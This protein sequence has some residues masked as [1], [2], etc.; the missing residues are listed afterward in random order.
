RT[1]G[2]V[3]GTTAPAR[4]SF[5]PARLFEGIV[6]M[7][8][9]RPSFLSRVRDL[10]R[11]SAAVSA[12][13]RLVHQPTGTHLTAVSARYEAAQPYGKDRSWL[14]EY[15]Q[16]ARQ[17]I[18]AAERIEMLRKSRYFEKNNATYQKILDLIEVNVVGTGVH[19]TPASDSP[20]WNKRA[21][22]Y[23]QEWCRYADLTSR[24]NF[25]TLEAL[26]VRA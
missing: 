6:P 22:R 10:F 3:S 2:E 26:I 12:E 20:E 11:P 14:P 13:V 9:A 7:N 25:N 21:L 15:V 18:N 19:A 8:A 16:D 4:H 5:F 24:Q 23:W 1:V 17:D